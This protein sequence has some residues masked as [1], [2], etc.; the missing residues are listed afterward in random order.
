MLFSHITAPFCK[1][2]LLKAMMMLLGEVLIELF[3]K[4]G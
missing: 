4:V 3:T 1:I 2:A